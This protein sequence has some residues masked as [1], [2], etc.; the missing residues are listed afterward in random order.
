MLFCAAPSQQDITFLF[1]FFV[2]M[3]VHL[4]TSCTRQ[5][6]NNMVLSGLSADAANAFLCGKDPRPCKPRSSAWAA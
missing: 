4:V 2:V 5:P 1:T 6:L 3:F